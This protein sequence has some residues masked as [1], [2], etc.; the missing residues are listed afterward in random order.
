[1]VYLILLR[2]FMKITKT[3]INNSNHLKGSD[4]TMKILLDTNIIIQREEDEVLSKD[5]ALLSRILS[6]LKF[7]I[8]VHPSSIEELKHD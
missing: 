4:L 2:K 1:M 7:E 5:L 8:Y 3:K 6:E